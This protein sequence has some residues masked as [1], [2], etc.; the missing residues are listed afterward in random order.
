MRGTRV[1]L[2]V[3]LLLIAAC[4][5]GQSVSVPP[6]IVIASDFPLTSPAADAQSSSRAI[7]LE[8]ARHSQIGRFKLAYEPLDDAPVITAAVKGVQNVRRMIAQ[9]RVLGYIGPFTSNG[10]FAQIQLANSAGLAMVNPSST[11]WCLTLPDPICNPEPAD[12]RATSNNFFR[13][14]APDPVQ[15]RAIAR[16]LKKVLQ[17]KRAAAFTMDS[18]FDDKTL[19]AF[20]NEFTRDGGEV[21]WSQDLP[22]TTND[23]RA[24]LKTADARGAEAIFAATENAPCQARAQ[25]KGIFPQGAY[26]LGMDPL[27]EDSGCIGNAADN[28]EGMFATVS[29]ADLGQSNDPAVRTL[30]QDYA[31]AYPKNPTMSPYAFAAYDCAAILIQ[32]IAQAIAEDNGGFPTRSQ[33]LEQIAKSQFNGLGG[34]YSFDSNGDAV[35]PLMA[36]YEVKGGQWVYLQQIDASVARA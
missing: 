15:G 22:N 24:F 19:E 17:V 4:Q 20:S 6:D 7:Q 12:L 13:I 5:P 3:L 32:A 8:I 26:F 28:A 33:V 18:P 16:Y 1:A 27:Q 36:L 9:G 14:A 34:T 10:S 21:V 11:N 29:V 23:F 2:S 25:M 35:S 31:R 30:V